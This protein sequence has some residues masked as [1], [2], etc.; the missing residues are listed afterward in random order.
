MTDSSPARPSRGVLVTGASRGIGAAVAA[1]FAARGDRVA[2]HFRG[3]RDRA[4]A[5]LAALP[6]DGHLL[7]RADLGDPAA[8]PPMVE[9]AVAGLGRVDVLVNNAAVYDDDPAAPDR[10]LGHRLGESSYEEWVAAWRRTV[11]VNLLGTANVTYCVVR[12]MIGTEPAAGVPRGRVVNIGSRGAYRGEPRV[13]AYGAT[14]AGVHSL[15]QSLARDLGPEG[16]AVTSVA[17]G[18]VAT[19]MA[20]ATLAGP[21]GDEVRGQSPFGRVAEPAEVAAAVLF[22]ASPE[23]EWASGTVLDLNGASYLR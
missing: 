16:I 10:R 12:H 18:F 21:R 3:A 23:A 5:V 9:A 15:G 2:V 14:K 1:A 19:D 20:A 6:G 22:L 4:E 11:D 17:P 7:V 8:A 13:P